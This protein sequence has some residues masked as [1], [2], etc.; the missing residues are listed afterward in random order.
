MA[1]AFVCRLFRSTEQQNSNPRPQRAALR[2]AEVWNRRRKQAETRVGRRCWACSSLSLWCSDS[3]GTCP[4]VDRQ[5]EVESAEQNKF[6]QGTCCKRCFCQSF[7]GWVAQHPSH[8]ADKAL[9][10]WQGPCAEWSV[11]RDEPE[12]KHSTGPS[13]LATILFFPKG[14]SLSALA[15]SHAT[16]FPHF[17]HGSISI[18]EADFA[19]QSP[20]PRFCPAVGGVDQAVISVP[21]C[22]GT[23]CTFPAGAQNCYFGHFLQIIFSLNV[24]C[25]WPGT[26]QSEHLGL[27][28]EHF[29]KLFILL[30]F[31]LAL[32]PGEIRDEAYLLVA[33]C[34][35]QLRSWA[36]VKAAVP[37][38]RAW[39]VLILNSQWA[40][41]FSG[42]G[43]APSFSLSVTARLFY[44]AHNALM[45]DITQLQQVQL[46][47]LVAA[48]CS[49]NAAI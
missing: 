3:G 48:I 38:Q 45:G 26:L 1:T 8:P 46:Q 18:S 35:G 19:N 24:E 37:G 31:C 4:G 44:C 22:W 9:P 2:W 7:S 28:V 6:G 13:P 20:Q 27:S 39:L 21:L 47:K 43:V 41:S 36:G 40:G 12:G 17:P 5:R 34:P 25:Y 32:L 30:V 33:A 49:L 14:C 29:A 10:T 23:L 15:L 11:L 16:T 42:D